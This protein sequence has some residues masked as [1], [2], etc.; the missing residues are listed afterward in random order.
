MTEEMEYKSLKDENGDR[1]VL[2]MISK[3]AKSLEMFAQL[4]IKM[5]EQLDKLDAKIESIADTVKLC[6]SKKTDD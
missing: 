3:V 5:S 2:M 1:R 6:L 4:H